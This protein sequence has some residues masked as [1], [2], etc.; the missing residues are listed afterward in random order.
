MSGM[1]VR[2]Y[3]HNVRP[4]QHATTETKCYC[5]HFNFTSKLRTIPSTKNLPNDGTQ[6]DIANVFPN[7]QCYTPT[8][9]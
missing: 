6:N 2:E 1:T 3:V 9:F 8:S 5:L 4:K 7:T